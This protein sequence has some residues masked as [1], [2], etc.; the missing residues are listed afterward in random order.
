[1]KSYRYQQ[2]LG[3]FFMLYRK[4][5]FIPIL[6][7]FWKIY[8]IENVSSK[9][10]V[11]K[12]VNGKEN[13]IE[14]KIILK[15]VAKLKDNFCLSLTSPVLFPND[16]QKKQ[17]PEAAYFLHQREFLARKSRLHLVSTRCEEGGK[18]GRKQRKNKGTALVYAPRDG[19]LTNTQR[20]NK[21][22]ST[23]HVKMGKL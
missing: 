19:S 10:C 6:A 11:N 20:E 17:I 13:V 2:Q 18:E 23:R 1:M 16:S 21:G 22:S 4:I 14:C 12:L 5:Y 15:N 8:K 9:Q 3:T 7:Y